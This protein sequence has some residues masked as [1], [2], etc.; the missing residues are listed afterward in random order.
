MVYSTSIDYL[1]IKI[2]GLEA[3]GHPCA[4]RE[5]AILRGSSINRGVPYFAS[6]AK[7]GGRSLTRGGSN[8]SPSHARVM[9]QGTCTLLASFDFST[10][11]VEVERRLCQKNAKSQNVVSQFEN[12]EGEGF[13]AYICWLV[14]PC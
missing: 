9:A 6:L 8:K 11:K 1:T 5:I 7:G 10:E 14:R 4:L 2:W 13:G 12:I 3:L